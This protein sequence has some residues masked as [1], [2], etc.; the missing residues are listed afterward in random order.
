MSEPVQLLHTRTHP[1]VSRLALGVGFFA[2]A[3]IA[4]ALGVTRWA[5]SYE[6]RIAPNVF[7]GLVPVGGLDASSAKLLVQHEVDTLLDRG[8]PVT[9]NGGQPATLVLATLVD[10]DLIDDAAIDVDNA[11]HA[12]KAIGHQEN[13]AMAALDLFKSLGD[14]QVISLPV[15]LNEAAIRRSL[16]SLYPNEERPTENARLIFQRQSD[17]WT[18]MA[19]EGKSGRSFDVPM[20]MTDLQNKLA[21]LGKATV[22]IRLAASEPLANTRVAELAKPAALAALAHAPYVFT[23]GQGDSFTSLTLTDRLLAQALGPGED[24]SLVL[25]HAPIAKALSAFAA[26]VEM[27]PQNA[28]FNIVDGRVT[29]F[30]PSRT[31]LKVDTEQAIHLLEQLLIR[32]PML[33]LE[34]RAIV[35]PV[36]SVEPEISTEKANDLGIVALLGAGTSSYAKSPSNRIKNIANG[37]KLLHGILISPGQTFSTVAALKPFTPENGYVPELVIKGDKIQPELGG[38]LCQIGT[39]TFRAALHAGFPIVERRNHS[40]VVSYYNDPANGNPGTDATVY[41]PAPDLKFTNDTGKYVLLETEM[42]SENKTLRFSFWG[43]PD[44]RK[45]SYTPP[46]VSH[47]IPVGEPREIPT[48]DLKP[49]EKKCQEAHIGADAYFDYTVEKADGTKETRTFNSHYRPLPKICLVGEDPKT[50]SAEPVIS[51]AGDAPIIE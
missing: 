34:D 23:H 47:W 44:G 27:K 45:S 30:A 9:L 50:K 22:N 7:I 4:S 12:A 35:L 1:R 25:D 42:I 13:G 43:T 32:A 24:G 17:A 5:A 29:E 51:P 48:K 49:G 14:R 26:T 19:T 15:A 8:V 28:R 33:A 39:T 37:V 2:L 41:E 40:L 16:K 46:T 21:T 11:I 6:N 31:G 10:G 38:G 18:A 36:T 20:F 3:F